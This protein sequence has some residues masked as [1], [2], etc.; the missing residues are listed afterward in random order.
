MIFAFTA[1]LIAVRREMV[2]N[3]RNDFFI[4]RCFFAKGFLLAVYGDV[5]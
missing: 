3:F 4:L 1:M 2:M 5:G